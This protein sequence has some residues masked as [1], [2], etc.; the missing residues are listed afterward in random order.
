MKRTVAIAILGVIC[1]AV[2]RAGD[3][4]VKVIMTTGPD[5]DR[6][7]IFASDTSKI[8][9]I[10]KTKGVKSGDKAHGVLIADDVGD[11][12]PANTKVVETS[13]TLDGDTDD[14]DFKFSKPTNGW[15]VGKYHV[16]IFVNDE[17]AATAKFT[18]KS[19]K[20][21]SKDEEESG[22]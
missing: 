4:S 15:P 3:V 16:E 10:F 11:A 7:T 22:D 13:V 18:V 21:K 5:D 17:L 6:T 9:A 14:G 8:Y 1:V 12:A 2:A 19:A 20:K